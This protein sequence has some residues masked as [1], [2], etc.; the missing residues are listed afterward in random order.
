M[1][2]I[3]EGKTVERQA[4]KYYMRVLDML[5]PVVFLGF[6]WTSVLYCYDAPMYQLDQG[7]SMEEALETPKI[8]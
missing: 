8:N 2:R 6:C 3:G 1:P 4:L 5:R 7:Q